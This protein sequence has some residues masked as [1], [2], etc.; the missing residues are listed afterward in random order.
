MLI[1]EMP[2]GPLPRSL[3]RVIVFVSEP[4]SRPDHLR[5]PEVGDLRPQLGHLARSISFCVDQDVLGLEVEVPDPPRVRSRETPAG[6]AVRVHEQ[7]R[8]DAPKL[9]QVAVEELEHQVGAVEIDLEDRDDV[10]VS[11]PRGEPRLPGC[12][13]PCEGRRRPDQLDDHVA[14]ELVVAREQQVRCVAS[15]VTD[16]DITSIARVREPYR[17][18]NVAVCQRLATLRSRRPTWSWRTG[19]S[20]ENETAG[21]PVEERVRQ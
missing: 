9:S 16:D 12:A 8:V 2:T 18:C 13:D 17:R 14:L 6:L 4:M 5:D 11:Q 15:Q 7:R 3:W 20:G 1:L 19:T 10:R 21:D